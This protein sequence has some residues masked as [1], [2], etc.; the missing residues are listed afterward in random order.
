MRMVLTG[1]GTGGHIYPALAV[2]GALRAIDP[3]ISI[4]YVGTSGGLEADL[5][6]G[7]GLDFR[8]V[9][10]RGILGKSPR[11]ALAGAAAA[12]RGVFEAVS[13]L[14]RLRPSAVLG[15]GGYVSGPVV[16]AAALL[17][18]PR[19]IQEQN[20]VPG[21]TNRALGLVA[22]RV[23]TAFE[24]TSG[25]PASKV[26]VTGNP[27][28]AEI[29][30]ATRDDSARSLGVDPARRTLCIFGGS[31]GARSIVNAGIRLVSQ[32]LGSD[33]QIIFVTGKEYYES[34]SEALASRRIGG[35]GAGNTILI[36]YMYNME[37]ALAC[38]D[39][40][41]CRAGGMAVAE[42]AA[43]GL[44]AILVPSPNVANNHQEYNAR[45]LAAEGAAVIVREGPGFEDRVVNEVTAL[46]N[47]RKRLESMKVAARAAGR[48]HAAS[49][50]ARGL[51]AMSR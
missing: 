50:I 23:F 2:A 16:L 34:A 47:D 6:K 11:A 42:M 43:R 32:G 29:L 19:A 48:P 26:V 31:R 18:I 9:S 5:V 45:A 35:G 36:P 15:T 27:V 14:R 3:G 4:T 22:N 7:Q 13:L 38:A 51:L 33:S 30:R 40:A 17:G 24:G 1:G 46:W 21:F 49:E 12:A 25:F 37:A 41:L 8:V 20:A 39:L 10:S 44:P 28:R